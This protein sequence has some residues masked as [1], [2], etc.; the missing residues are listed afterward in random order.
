[1]GPT[2]C[3]GG[4]KHNIA[5]KTHALTLY[6]VLAYTL[7]WVVW[8]PAVF[9]SFGYT[10]PLPARYLHL[11]GGMGPMLAAILVS[12]WLGGVPALVTLGKR[13]LRGGVWLVIAVAI[14]A[15]AFLLALAVVAMLSGQAPNWSNLGRNPELPELSASLSVLAT[16]LCYGFGEEVGWRG[17]ALPRLQAKHSAL[18]S[19]WLLSLA[20]AGWHLPLFC[21]AAGLS[22][23]GLGG[24]AGWLMSLALGSVLLTWLFNSSGGAISAAA[25]LH[26]ALDVFT[27]APVID[28]PLL[29]NV[30]GATLSVG[31]LLLIP[32]FGAENLARRPRI[33][34]SDAVRGAS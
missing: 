25:L 33:I 4:T 7:S 19:S 2:V 27:S 24:A 13:C 6:F 11:I 14:P 5:M 15:A 30:I 28:H 34:E 17:F 10:P 31:A 32:V 18:H 3:L 9:A 16:V 23:L 26:A 1:M 20:W 8:A 21:F 12:A 29:P 22:R